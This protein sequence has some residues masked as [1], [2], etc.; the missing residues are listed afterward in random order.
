MCAAFVVMASVFVPMHSGADGLLLDHADV[1]QPALDRYSVDP[2]E[3]LRSIGELEHRTYHIRVFATDGGPRF[4]IYDAVDGSEI[5]ALM[6]AE[7]ISEL[8]PELPLDKI[9]FSSPMQI[10]MVDPNSTWSR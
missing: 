4:S 6:S 3:G 7:R 1:D 9:D 8:F 5:A 10:M 2:H